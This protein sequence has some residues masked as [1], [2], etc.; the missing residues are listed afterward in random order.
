MLQQAA[1]S[2]APALLGRALAIVGAV[3]LLPLLAL[4][5]VGCGVLDDDPFITFSAG[6]AG[7]RDIYVVRADGSGLQAAV[8]HPADDFA[9]VWSPDRTRIAYLSDREGNVEVYVTS[10]L[11]EPANPTSSMRVTHTGVDESHVRW[12][13][14]G[15][16]LLYVSPEGDGTP[17]VYWVDLAN[18]RPNRLLFGPIGE[19]DP[20]WSPDGKWVAFS[21]LDEDGESMGIIL[22]NPDGVNSVQVTHTA[23]YAPAWS[24]DSKRLAFVSTRRGNQD[25]YVADVRDDGS[26][27]QQVNLTPN[28]AD[29]WGPVWDPGSGRLLFFSNRAGPANIMAVEAD[30]SGLVPLTA[31]DARQTAIAFGPDGMLVFASVFSGRSDIFLMDEDGANQRLLN[32]LNLP[33][34]HP[35]W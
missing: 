31:N 14:D 11:T 22:R 26:I 27:S 9:P 8:F 7:A 28:P 6:Q 34:F 25:V 15:R 16:R 12:S 30:G 10:S 18:L 29:D 5:A 4:I 2:A 32:V 21:V 3:F 19:Q 23:D 20:A 33:G 1:P 13:P 24:P 35:D 17:R